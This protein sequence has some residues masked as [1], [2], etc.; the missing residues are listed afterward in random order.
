[1]LMCTLGWFAIFVTKFAHKTKKTGKTKSG[2]FCKYYIIQFLILKLYTGDMLFTVG[3]LKLM[4]KL[5]IDMPKIFF[6]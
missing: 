3:Q 2:I 4:N 6:R 5:V 1:M